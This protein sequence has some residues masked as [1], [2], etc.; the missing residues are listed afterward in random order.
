MTA[1]GPSQQLVSI[2]AGLPSLPKKT[3]DRICSNEYIDFAELPPARGKSRQLPQVLDGQVIVLQ[4]AD[5]LQSRRVIPDLAT[6]SQCYA[7]YVAALVP[8]QPERLPELMAYQS[9]IAKAST[10]YKWPSWVVYD[11]NF[12]Q[13]AAGNPQLSWTKVD[14]S[15]YAQCFTNQ[16]ISAENW[17]DK[18]HALD[19]TFSKCPSRS[20]KRPWSAASPRYQPSSGDEEICKKYNRFNGDC[21]FGADCRFQHVCLIMKCKEAHPVSRCKAGGSGNYVA[22]PSSTAKST[23]L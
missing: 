19:H 23:V 22:G 1:P 8:H 12:R 20:R 7:L 11:Q 9:L 16:A 3:V 21:K 17:C 4:A 2:G 13:D 18:C 15:I 6:W 10:K 5:L 14:P